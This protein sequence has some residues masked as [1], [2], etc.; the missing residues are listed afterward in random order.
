MET[1]E[2]SDFIK[3]TLV[4]VA[5]GVRDANLA[6]KETYNVGDDYFSLQG[7]RGDK[8]VPG[9]SF[10]I[11]I[12]ASKNQKDKAGFMVALATLGGGASTEKGLAGETAHRI[13]FEVALHYEF[14]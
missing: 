6:L 13:Q 4:D 1:V 8:K 7:M 5:K 3:K 9:I 10:D 2:L 14:Q 12:N 11:A